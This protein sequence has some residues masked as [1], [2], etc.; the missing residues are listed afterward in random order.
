MSTRVTRGKKVDID[1]SLIPRTR[2]ERKDTRDK[3][4]AI[5]Q[6]AKAAADKELAEKEAQ[7]K[8]AIALI[9]DQRALDQ[10]QRQ[11]LR[12]DLINFLKD[13]ESF[14]SG[15]LFDSVDRQDVNISEH[16]TGSEYVSSRGASELDDLSFKDP[17]RDLSD[18][19]SDFDYKAELEKLKTARKEAKGKA[20]KGA[21][22][23]AKKQAQKSAVRDSVSSIRTEPPTNSV[24]IIK[25]GPTA[26]KRARDS[27]STTINIATKRPRTEIGG[28]RDNARTIL[29]ASTATP[30]PKKSNIDSDGGVTQGDLNSEDCLSSSRSAT[31]GKPNGHLSSR[32]VDVQAVISLV[33]AN[34]SIIDIK[35]RSTS[36]TSK[37]TNTEFMPHIFDF[38][39]A[40][41]Y[42]FG[43]STNVDLRY[44][45]KSHWVTV[46]P[47]LHELKDHPT[48]FPF[49]QSQIRTYRSKFG[50]RAL[51]AVG[52]AVSDA[53]ED[54][55]GRIQFVAGELAEDAWAYEQPG[56][57]RNTSTGAMRSPLILETFAHHF[58][59]AK[60]FK[61]KSEFGFP[62]GALALSAAAVLRAFRAY[63]NG[64]NS[65]EDTRKEQEVERKK[66]GKSRLSRN[67]ETSFGEEPWAD[68][69]AEYYKTIY[70][71]NNTKWMVIFDGAEPFINIKKF[72]KRQV[73]DLTGESRAEASGETKGN[74]DMTIVL[75]DS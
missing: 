27:T 57:T 42:Q 53:A 55:L 32:H 16:Y 4:A 49:V 14:D 24:D 10:A 52:R 48:I 36:T 43:L 71:A 9:E 65:I 25:G 19:D 64:T 13:N 30:E 60:S 18:S 7:A 20:D 59:H 34:V 23:G 41:Q 1:P 58:E 68:Y 17:A 75:S 73:V 26:I 15:D 63:E 22:A 46:Y 45:I 21:T 12:P 44:L 67:T 37:R 47:L 69:S 61:V 6:N 38:V 70:Q 35:E 2:I 39:G 54:I 56:A 74:D 28:L 3:K 5:I 8:S 31:A 11:S 62:A 33:P 40:Q 51:K 72:E 50:K 29:Q 66:E